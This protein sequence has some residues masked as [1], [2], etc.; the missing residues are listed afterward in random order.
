MKRPG[1]GQ[2]RFLVLSGAFGLLVLAPLLN[3]HFDVNFVQGWYQSLGI[4]DFW[5]VSPLEG[6]ESLLVTRRLF[7]PLVTALLVP[8]L[9][10]VIMGRVFC[11][12]ICPITF[13]TELGEK[14]TRIFSKKSSIPER[15]GLVRQLLWLTL[16]LE[17]LVTL[18]LGAPVFVF[19][20]PPGLVGRQLMTLIFFHSLTLEGVI[21]LLALGLN[22]FSRR[23]YCRYLCPLG[24]F[25]ALLGTRRRLRLVNDG[26]ACRSCGAC[27]RSCPMGL[28]PSLG[29]GTTV[30]CWNC[31][32]CIDSC[33]SA[34]LRFSLTGPEPRLEE[35][36]DRSAKIFQ[37]TP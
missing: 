3:Y 23:C 17:L 2:R 26:Q 34:H 25:L 36:P 9:L 28:K 14:I 22:L 16:A 37:K 8:T 7:G 35:K 30:Y 6:L 10:A 18:V 12:W 13:L 19:L 20:S 11:S 5:I 29:E 32:S 33:H 27:D 21:I 1:W 24:A 4:G 15:L 31:G